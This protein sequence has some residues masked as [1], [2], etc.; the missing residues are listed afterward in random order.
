MHNY[1]YS[2]AKILFPGFVSTYNCIGWI[3][4]SRAIRVFNVWR[5]KHFLTVHIV[6]PSAH[7]AQ[8]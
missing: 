6:F 3:L 5:R 2:V 4:V 1:I 8:C 7:A